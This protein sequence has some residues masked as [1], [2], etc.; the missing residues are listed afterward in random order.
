[1]T[2]TL[3]QLISQVQAMFIDDGTRFTANTITA[4]I[5]QALKDFN[6]AAPVRAAET[7]TVV[8]GQYEYE[9]SD[10][11]TIQVLDVLLEGTDTL[12][13]NHIPLAFTP[14]FEDG[15]AWIRLIRPL[16]SGT[17][18]IRYTIPHTVSGLDGSV[19]STLAALWDAVLLDGACYYSALM[20]AASRIEVV[21]LNANVPDPWQAIAEHYLQ[22]FQAGLILATR[23]PAARVPDKTLQPRT[24]N[25]EWH[26][27]PPRHS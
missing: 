27:F 19:E 24:W 17:L 11:T 13:E 5:R 25:D 2:Q 1:M 8:S 4:S 6:A 14:Y 26:N 23:Q 7:Q 10:I 20:R 22:A 9:L 3:T 15:R 18:I 21:N 12:Q 16:G